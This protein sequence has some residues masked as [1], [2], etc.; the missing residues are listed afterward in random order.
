M[1]DPVD[2]IGRLL[3]LVRGAAAFA[4]APHPVNERRAESVGD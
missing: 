3:A 2:R 4:A 1:T